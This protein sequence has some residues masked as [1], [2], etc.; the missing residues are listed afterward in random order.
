MT[1]T[2]KSVQ[3]LPDEDDSQTIEIFLKA[4]SEDIELTRTASGHQPDIPSWL[5][6]ITT[7]EVGSRD[8]PDVVQAGQ[9]ATPRMI[10]SQEGGLDDRRED[11]A[12]AMETGNEQSDGR[13]FVEATA[14][15]MLGSTPSVMNAKDEDATDA[16][17]D[18]RGVQ[19]SFATQPL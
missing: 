4:I 9:S 6:P 12:F 15:G 2:T 13:D 14:L 10:Q 16:G 17:T 8:L 18:E 1:T 3:T 7:M 19:K 5:Y 11:L